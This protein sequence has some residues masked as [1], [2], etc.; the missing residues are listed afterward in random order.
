MTTCEWN[1]I[2][3]RNEHE[4][5]AG[6]MFFVMLYAGAIDFVSVH[7]VGLRKEHPRRWSFE[8]GVK[9]QSVYV[10]TIRPKH[11]SPR[12]L[13]RRW[14]WYGD[15][16]LMFVRFRRGSPYVSEVLNGRH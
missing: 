2:Q 4:R 13:R 5:K 15:R 1:G 8:I 16:P 6:E 12:A 9:G 11:R 7:P 3:F 14:V 10:K